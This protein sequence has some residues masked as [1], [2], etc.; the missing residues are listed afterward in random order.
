QHL[1]E[2]I[3]A[4]T[5]SAIMFTIFMGITSITYKID[6]TGYPSFL[7]ELLTTNILAA[8]VMCFIAY[9]I[10]VLTFR[11]ALDPD[12][13]VIPIESSIADAVT[14]VFLFAALTMFK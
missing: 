7:G 13:F 2:I 4:W 9:A 8:S 11:R 12:N 5:A 3:S 14:T 10:A 6:M 1:T